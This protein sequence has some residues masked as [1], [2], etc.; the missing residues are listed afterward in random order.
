[1]P[2]FIHSMVHNE[3]GHGSEEGG[4]E[5]KSRTESHSDSKKFIFYGLLGTNSSLTKALKMLEDH[6]YRFKNKEY[7]NRLHF[8]WR[9]F[10]DTF[11]KPWL[12]RDFDP[13]THK[14]KGKLKYDEF[15]AGRLNLKQQLIKSVISRHGTDTQNDKQTLQEPLLD[16][17]RKEEVIPIVQS[18]DNNPRPMHKFSNQISSPLNENSLLISSAVPI[19]DKAEALGSKRQSIA[20]QNKSNDYRLIDLRDGSPTRPEEKL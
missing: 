13:E 20:S 2:K 11:M 1:M 8:Y 3:G 19:D 6:V 10:D 12:I 18:A 7:S 4:Q 9:V 14:L 5:M 15:G 16:K 17:E